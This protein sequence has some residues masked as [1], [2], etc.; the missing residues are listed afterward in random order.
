[1]ELE[2]AKVRNRPNLRKIHLL[3]GKQTAC[4][5]DLYRSYAPLIRKDQSLTRKLVS[6]QGNKERPGL[7]WM[8]YKEGFSSDLVRSLLDQTE[9][10]KVLDPFSGIGTTCTSPAK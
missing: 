4:R 8:K 9:A 1:M 10:K 6:Y 5:D 3:S 2:Q 7:R